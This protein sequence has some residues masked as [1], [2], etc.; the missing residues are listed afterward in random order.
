MVSFSF[1][2]PEI[3][4]GTYLIAAGIADGTQDNHIRHQYIADAYELQFSSLDLRQQQSV[5][6]KLENCTTDVMVN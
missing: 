2:F 1:V 3:E 5:I 6:F 4:N